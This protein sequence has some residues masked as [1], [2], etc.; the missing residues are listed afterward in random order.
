M[1]AA[2]R[3]SEMLVVLRAETGNPEV[4]RESRAQVQE[5]K[6]DIYKYFWVIGGWRCP[7]YH[8]P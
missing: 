5:L 8:F 2:Q 4:L 3:G 6:G 1:E 7:P